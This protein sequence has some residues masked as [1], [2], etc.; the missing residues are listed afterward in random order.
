MQ[1]LHV[2]AKAWVEWSWDGC[3]HPH[4]IN[5]STITIYIYC[6]NRGKNH[7]FLHSDFVWGMFLRDFFQFKLMPW[8]FQKIL[9]GEIPNFL[10]HQRL[11]HHV[12]FFVLLFSF[13][14]LSYPPF[15]SIPSLLYYIVHK[16]IIYNIYKHG[17]GCTSNPPGILLFLLPAG[18]EVWFGW[19]ID[20]PEQWLS[21]I[22]SPG[23]GFCYFP[24]FHA[25]VCV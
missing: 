9:E 10:I 18:E 25:D 21:S 3:G 19:L 11:L 7:Q 23:I 5:G 24:Q 22:V 16:Y 2:E 8:R 20:L 17:E 14:R 6:K 15:N 12:L 4:K 1:L 13:R